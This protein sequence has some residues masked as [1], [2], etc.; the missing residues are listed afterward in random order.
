MV[1]MDQV[2]TSVSGRVSH[3]WDFVFRKNA[4]EIA[5]QLRRAFGQDLTEIR[6][7]EEGDIVIELPTQG[8]FFVTPDSV[9]AGGWV[10]LATNLEQDELER[11]ANI[12]RTI[13]EI[14]QASSPDNYSVRLFF[15][16]TP[17]D[18][19]ALLRNDFFSHSL[20]SILS[21]RTP[22]DLESLK[23]SSGYK[24][25]KFRDFVEVEASTK[26][27]QLRYSRSAS[28]TE[29]DS[30]LKFLEACKLRGIVDT[31][32]PVGERLKNAEPKVR[33]GSLI[34]P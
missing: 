10:T 23:F 30:Y 14:K 25:G 13:T 7:D 21:D 24:N 22:S 34:N 2:A 31:L 27:V 29:F 33:I 28:A 4:G 8:S 19:L 9:I 5:N 17:E 11:F 16:F 12:V 15:R 20:Q 32:T 3:A 26:N 18:G 6:I 1:T